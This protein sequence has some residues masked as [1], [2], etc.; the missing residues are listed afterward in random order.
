M[1]GDVPLLELVT[2]LSAPILTLYG[3][4]SLPHSAGWRLL[5]P[6]AKSLL[7]CRRDA[8]ATTSA[9]RRPRTP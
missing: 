2:A 7:T 5:G 3:T 1:A 8:P 6:C 4:R 9:D